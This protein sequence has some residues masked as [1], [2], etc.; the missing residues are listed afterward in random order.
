MRSSKIEQ[1]AAFGRGEARRRLVEQQG[2]G[3][4]R[5][6]QRDL[7]QPPLAV[8]QI[9]DAARREFEQAELLQQRRRAI[10]DL[11]MVAA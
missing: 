2:L 8:G 10:D 3:L 7:D 4:E 6:H 1:R 5:Q 9:G 11:G